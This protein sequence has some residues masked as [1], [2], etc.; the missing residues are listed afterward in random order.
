MDLSAAK[1]STALILMNA[2]DFLP[3]PAVLLHTL[4][5]NRAEFIVLETTPR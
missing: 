2:Q 4:S 5:H 1:L 3:D